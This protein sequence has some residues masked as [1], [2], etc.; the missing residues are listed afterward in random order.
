VIIGNS[1]DGGEAKSYE[2][3]FINGEKGWEV[4]QTEV[5]VAT[6]E[7]NNSG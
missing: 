7:T 2:E 6:L 1:E 4:I 5:F 3:Q